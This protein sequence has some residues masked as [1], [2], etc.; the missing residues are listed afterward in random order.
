M[1]PIY[2][3]LYVVRL[4]SNESAEKYSNRRSLLIRI[5]LSLQNSYKKGLLSVV[6]LVDE[7]SLRIWSHL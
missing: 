5:G 3:M 6:D 2:W 4:C 1:H 7:G